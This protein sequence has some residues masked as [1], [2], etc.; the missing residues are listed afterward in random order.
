MT[1]SFLVPNKRKTSETQATPFST[2]CAQAQ[3]RCHRIGQTR[4]V[5]IYRL[6][7]QHTIEENILRKSACEVCSNPV[8]MSG[9]GFGAVNLLGNRGRITC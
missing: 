8:G 5:H 4:E 7:T 1:L 2:P 3:D 6:V 9:I